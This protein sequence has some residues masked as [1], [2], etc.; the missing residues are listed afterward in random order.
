MLP[1]TT[2]T[3]AKHNL[4]IKNTKN[5]DYSFDIFLNTKIL[6]PKYKAHTENWYPEIDKLSH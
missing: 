2:K 1:H 5:I 4:Y 3:S 6:L